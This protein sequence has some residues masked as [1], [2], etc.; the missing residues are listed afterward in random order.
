MEFAA[1]AFGSGTRIDT[2]RVGGPP[3]LPLIVRAANRHVDLSARIRAH[4]IVRAV[5]DREGLSTEHLESPWHL[6]LGHPFD[7]D[8]PGKG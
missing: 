8:V 2:D 4:R 1:N 7:H 6:D 3:S 5:D